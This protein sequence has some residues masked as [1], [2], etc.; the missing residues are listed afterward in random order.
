MRSMFPVWKEVLVSVTVPSLPSSG[1][2]RPTPPGITRPLPSAF[3]WMCRWEAAVGSWRADGERGW[4]SLNPAPRWFGAA[5]ALRA[6]EEILASAASQ[7]QPKCQAGPQPLLKSQPRAPAASCLGSIHDPASLP[8]VG[9]SH[10]SLNL[11]FLQE[12]IYSPNI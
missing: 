2:R 8:R 6:P 4:T 9:F 10:L 3:G 7:P 11:Y 12:S 5:L 1:P